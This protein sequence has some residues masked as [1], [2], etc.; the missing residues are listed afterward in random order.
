[1]DISRFSIEEFENFETFLYRL[2]KPDYAYDR[3]VSMLVN[4]P[5][6]AALR[7]LIRATELPDEGAVCEAIAL[8]VGLFPDAGAVICRQFLSHESGTVRR[9]S[10]DYLDRVPGLWEEEVLSLLNRETDGDTRFLAVQYLAVRGTRTALKALERIAETDTATDY[11][12]RKVSGLAKK[13]IAAIHAKC[14]SIV[15][16]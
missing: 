2:R 5:R 11:E 10:V 3:F 9:I 14:G 7:N 8:L 4:L 13:A 1:M 12:G 16:R 6:A 15:D